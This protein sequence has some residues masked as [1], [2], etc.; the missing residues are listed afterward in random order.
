M[1]RNLIEES[2]IVFQKPKLGAELCS[3]AVRWWTCEPWIFRD[4]IRDDFLEIVFPSIWRRLF[5]ELQIWVSHIILIDRLKEAAEL[6]ASTVLAK[7]S[8]F[9]STWLLLVIETGFL[10]VFH[11]LTFTSRARRIFIGLILLLF[12]KFFIWW[13]RILS[14]YRLSVFEGIVSRCT[15][16]SSGNNIKAFI[17]LLSRN[18]TGRLVLG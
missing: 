11:F 15:V 13:I 18:D 10:L 2:L 17:W 6:L 12:N 1:L 16:T 8:L 5:G 4:F 7:E 14:R 9:I 3:Q